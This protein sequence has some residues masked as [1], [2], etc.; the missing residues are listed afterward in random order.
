[1]F[2]LTPFRNVM[3]AKYET[4]RERENNVFLCEPETF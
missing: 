1:M 2:V 4:L 3:N